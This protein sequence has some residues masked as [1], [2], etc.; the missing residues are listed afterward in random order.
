MERLT[1]WTGEEWIAVQNRVPA[2]GKKHGKTIGN[3]D[4]LKRLAEYE[5][6]GLTPE[7]I[8]ELRARGELQKMHKPNPNT[9]CCPECGE[10]IVPMWDYCPWCGQ[11]VTDNQY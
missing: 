7:E 5:N 1:E 11:H 4:C 3:R 6:T 8:E 10:K 9:Y 2:P